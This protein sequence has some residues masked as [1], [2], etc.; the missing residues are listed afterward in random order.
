MKKNLIVLSI[1]MVVF[2]AVG[3]VSAYTIDNTTDIYSNGYSLNWLSAAT[4]SVGSPLFDT[5]G[6]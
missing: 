6:G 2:L 3:G 4:A 1:L 5:Q